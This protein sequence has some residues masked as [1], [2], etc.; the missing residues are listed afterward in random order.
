[1]IKFDKIDKFEKSLPGRLFSFCLRAGIFFLPCGKIL[2]NEIVFG[3]EEWHKKAL[4]K[5]FRRG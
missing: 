2:K 5:K 1:L 3:G 4:S